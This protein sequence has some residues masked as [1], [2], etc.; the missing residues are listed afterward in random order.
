MNKFLVFAALFLAF[1]PS[2]AYAHPVIIES[3]PIQSGNAPAGINHII[4]HYSEAIEVNFSTIKVIDSSGNQIDNKDTKYFDVDSSLVVTT[5]PLDDGVYTVTSKVLSKVDGHVVDDA[6]SFGVGDVRI[7]PPKQKDITDS[8]YFPEAAARLPGIVGQVIVLGSVISSLLLWRTIQ[9]KNLIKE[10]LVELQKFYRSKFF[11]IIGIGL[12]AVFASNILM[13]LVQTLR[14][15][16]SASSVLETSFGSIW[17]IRMLITVVLIAVWFLMENKSSFSYKKQITLLGLSLLLISTTTLIGHGTA[18]EQLAPIAIDYIHNLI[19]SIWIGGLIFFGFILLP[20]L[21]KLDGNKKDLITLLMIPRFSS[22][23][24]I[25]LGILI[26]TG[27]TLLWFLQDNVQLLT[28]SY[29][30][31]MIMAK[32]AIAGMMIGLGG[33]NQFKIQKDGTEA[34]ESSNTTHKKLKRSL[35]TEAMLGIALLGFV[36]LLTNT[37]L[38][39]ISENQASA[40]QSSAGLQTMVFSKN[41]RFDV[42]LEPFRAGKNSITISAYDPDG[43]PLDDVSSIGIKISNPQKNIVPIE[44]PLTESEKQARY[45]GEI[46]FG[47][48]GK[49]NV[50]IEAQRTEHENEVASMLVNVKPHVSDIKAEITEISLPDG[51]SPLYP[52][53]DGNDAIWLSDSTSPRLWK[54]SISK[55]N[56]TSYKFDGKASVFLKIDNAG[57]VWFTDSPDSKI[58]YFDPTTEQFTLVPLPKKAIPVSLETDLDDNMWVALIDQHSLLKYSQETRQFK[59]YK[60]PTNPSGPAIIKRDAGGNIWFAELE[61]GKIGMIDPRTEEFKEFVPSEPLKEP[62]ALFID[63]NGNIWISEHV[64]LDIVKFNPVLQT[65]ETA[66][67]PLTDQNAL[68][69]GLASDRFGNIWFAQHTADNL[70]VYD[71]DR[72]EFRD[73]PIPTKLTLTQ[74]ITSDNDGNLWFA[75]AGTK[76]LGKVTISELPPSD[77][78][79]NQS[80]MELRYSEFAAPFISAGIIATSLFFVKSIRDKRK[81]DELIS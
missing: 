76:K 81:I 28:N 61:G 26:I 48:S 13:L 59:E 24:V 11:S 23:V 31:Y 79:Q 55:E 58:G 50:E 9:S 29:Y 40:Q 7:P 66:T 8:I 45:E 21:T 4:I 5:P 47:F 54:Y 60:I 73:I 41:V 38:P 74:F 3:D 71:P 39:V 46:T 57:K 20:T 36:A 18:T 32:I 52:T 12:F 78:G 49:W 70:G 64:G 42:D 34:I 16:I 69:F 27:P 80:G 68:P 25:S 2:L 75:E 43:N 6:F 72:D 35:R 77:I 53:F 63:E 22:I 30:G 14:L 51:A 37:S 44:V 65:F 10:D 19:A 15:Q 33:Y 67:T 1:I 56:F 62:T 17:L